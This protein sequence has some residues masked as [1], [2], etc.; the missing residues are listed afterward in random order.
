MIPP[1]TITQWFWSFS[2]QT[3]ETL[4]AESVFGIVIIGWI[5]QLDFFKR[6]AIKDGVFLMIFPK[7]NF[8]NVLS[9]M[10]EEIFLEAFS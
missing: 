9:K 8:S 6:D 3:K 4:A 10:C 2:E 5:G 7:S 1:Q